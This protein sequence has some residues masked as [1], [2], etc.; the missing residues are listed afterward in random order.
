MFQNI[1]CKSP[2]ILFENVELMRNLCLILCRDDD[3]DD[4]DPIKRLQKKDSKLN[5]KICSSRVSLTG[6]YF[7]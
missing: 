5:V 4:D 6:Y 7:Y 2:K 3:D 1:V